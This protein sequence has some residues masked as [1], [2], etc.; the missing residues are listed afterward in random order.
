M[1]DL[2]AFQGTHFSCLLAKH[3]LTPTSERPDTGS[4]RYG[5]GEPTATL[6]FCELP[7]TQGFVIKTLAGFFG[8]MVVAVTAGDQ[9]A[10]CT[11]VLVISISRGLFIWWPLGCGGD[12]P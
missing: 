2:A 5:Y 3:A 9:S 7:Y 12:Y 8:G 4:P 11:F 10:R 6:Q 1:W